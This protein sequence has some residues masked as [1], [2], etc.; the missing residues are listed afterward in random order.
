MP[1]TIPH[2]PSYLPPLVSRHSKKHECRHII[3]PIRNNH[4]T[5]GKTKRNTQTTLNGYVVLPQGN[6][7]AYGDT[8]PPK[9]PQTLRLTFQNINGVSKEHWM[10][11][12]K[13]ILRKTKQLQ[14]D[15]AGFAEMNLNGQKAAHIDQ[16]KQRVTTAFPTKSKSTHSY[17]TT[18]H[19]Q[20]DHVHGGVCMIATEEANVRCHAQD[21]DPTGLGRWTSL[22]FRG[23]RGHRFRVI[24]AYNPVAGTC[25]N[26]VM[27][28]HRRYFRRNLDN[29]DPG[30]KFQEDLER[31]LKAWI[32]AG[33]ITILMLDAN[34]DIR[35]GPL[36]TMLLNSGLR[37]MI[38]SQHT[39]CGPAP[40][41]YARNE[42]NTP[43]DGIF[44]N[45][46]SD[47]Q[48]KCGYLGFC[49]GVPGDH[50]MAWI[51]IPYLQAF[52]HNPPHL[53]ATQPVRLTTT[54]PRVVAL[55]HKRVKIEF[56]KH[57]VYQLVTTI[58]QLVRRK[59]IARRNKRR[60]IAQKIEALYNKL[61]FLNRAIRKSVEK[62]LRKLR[63]GDMAYSE[64]GQAAK[65]QY[66]LWINVLKLHNK[67]RVSRRMIQRQMKSIGVKHAFDVPVI[68]VKRR[69][70]H[71]K[72]EY[73]KIKKDPAKHRESWLETLAK[74]IAKDKD[75]PKALILKNLRHREKQR[76]EARRCRAITGKGADRARTTKMFYT[77]T[78][79]LTHVSRRVECD[80]QET[81]GAAGAAAK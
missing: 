65:D 71:Y 23:K 57:G 29:S 75:Q 48:Y 72:A 62:K 61:S 51:D 27:E 16:W 58:T 2:P 24:T 55:Y 56:E 14:S 13:E 59:K 21:D 20:T 38:L 9:P 35:E 30:M 45:L 39:E 15:V 79:P 52:G 81:M 10:P 77:T 7:E 11:K 68:E 53:H 4:T 5:I 60:E 70:A 40:A 67:V 76:N 19:F 6:D 54:D 31:A 17:N 3:I 80:T 43:I 18:E 8:L 22:L 41:T 46:P 78:D 73:Y 37:E 1:R 74:A 50:R 63:M 25:K 42:S 36:R 28:Q 49:E 26:S 64:A 44:S 33:E 34:Q 12:S 66:E 32:T 47:I 69:I